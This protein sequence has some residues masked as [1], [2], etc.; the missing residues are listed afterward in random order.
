MSKN[1][2]ETLEQTSPSP[3]SFFQGDASSVVRPVSGPALQCCA[4][5]FISFSWISGSMST[6]KA[7]LHQSNQRTGWKPREEGRADTGVV[8]DNIIF[9]PWN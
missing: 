5:Y 1:G 3:A 7:Y 9:P 8:K 6:L 4:G 2:G